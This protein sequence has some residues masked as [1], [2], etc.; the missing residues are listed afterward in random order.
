MKF[1]NFGCKI[2]VFL[3]AVLQVDPRIHFALNCGAKSC[4]PIKTF[5]SKVR[6]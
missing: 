6:L 4:P 3:I 5:S 1:L 2:D